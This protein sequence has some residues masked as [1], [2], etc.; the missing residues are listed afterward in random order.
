MA[1]NSTFEET[2]LPLRTTLRKFAMHLTNNSE[3]ANDLLQDTFL[4]AFRFWNQFQQGTN[5]R[6]WLHQIM[7]NVFINRYR[8]EIKEP[9][10]VSYEE[11]HLPSDA[12][13]EAVVD[14]CGIL[15]RGCDEIYGDEVLRSI[16]SMSDTF[17]NVV[18]LCDGEGFNYDEIARLLDC[19]V[20]TVRSRIHRGRKL[21][22]HKLFAYARSQGYLA[23][24]QVIDY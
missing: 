1:E 9:G 21:L 5:I 18:L 22:R 2:A 13:Q 11:Y 10:K 19:P 12:L 6:G 24:D 8:K 16:E 15:E 14:E 20:G 7:R 4:N 17:R 23:K 3:N